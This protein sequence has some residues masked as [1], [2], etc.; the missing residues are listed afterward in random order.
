MLRNLIVSPSKN[1][2][3]SFHKYTYLI[4]KAYEKTTKPI[5][6]AL[7]IRPDSYKNQQF[8]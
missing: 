5:H 7:T 2:K 6:D 4:T 1:I 8:F 3:R